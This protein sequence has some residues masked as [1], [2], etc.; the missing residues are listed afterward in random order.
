V[1]SLSR[2]YL[3]SSWG[4]YWPTLWDWPTFAGTLGLFAALFFLFVRVLP[5]ISIFEMRELLPE[6]EGKGEHT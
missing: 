1:Q 3:P 6:A 5:L 2:D 4:N